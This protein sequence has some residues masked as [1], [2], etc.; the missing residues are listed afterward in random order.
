MAST[1]T[2]NDS[3][4]QN[5]NEDD[6]TALRFEDL[7]IDDELPLLDRVVR[8][9]RS[10]I[11]LQRLVHVKMLS[12]TAVT[13]GPA[14][15]ISHLI[16][17]LP[18]LVNDQE[19]IIRQ[20]LAMQLLPVSLTCMGLRDVDPLKDSYDISSYLSVP[21][22]KIQYD[23]YE[24]G[25]DIVMDLLLPK[26]LQKLISDQDQDVRKAA[27]DSI[28]K[29]SP[30]LRQIDVLSLVLP[31]ALNLTHVSVTTPKNS[32]K[33]N[34]KSNLQT[35]QQQQQQQQPDHEELKISAA[36]L[37]SYLSI[38]PSM[39]EHT[40]TNV[41]SPTLISL[42]KD[43]GSSFRVR[44]AIAQAIPRVVQKSSYENTKT[45]L[46]P[47]FLSLSHDDMYRV[48]KACAESLVDLS[49]GLS[50][51]PKKLEQRRKELIPLCKRLLNDSNK[52]VR[53]GMM[54]FLGPFIATFF[55]L[56]SIQQ[57][58]HHQQQQTSSFENGILPNYFPHHSPVSRVSSTTQNEKT[59]TLSNK[60]NLMSKALMSDQRML[61]EIM[62][63]RSQNPPSK[64]DIQH[65]KQDLIPAFCNMAI[66]KSGDPNIDAEMRVHCAYSLPAAALVLG[67]EEWASL[68]GAFFALVNGYSVKSD[69]T[70]DIETNSHV[71]EQN[72][73]MTVPTLAA[74]RCLASSLHSLAYI[75]G[76]TIVESELLPT[77]SY[78]FLKDTDEHV[79]LNAFKNLSS[80]L[81]VLRPQTRLNFLGVLEEFQSSS[82]I[83]RNQLN[84]RLRNTV[85]KQLVFFIHLYEKQQVHDVI[86]NTLFSL[87]KDPVAKVREDTYL[88]FPIILL[89]F[90]PSPRGKF[91]KEQIKWEEK[92]TKEIVNWLV[93]ELGRNKSD[94]SNRQ[95][96]CRI[97]ASIA[98]AISEGTDI[99]LEKPSNH[100]NSVMESDIDEESDTI[101]TNFTFSEASTVD[102]SSLP[103]QDFTLS[104]SSS[105]AGKFYLNARE[106]SHLHKILVHDLLSTALK[107]KDDN[108]T[109]VRLTLFKT[110][111]VMPGK[112]GTFRVTLYFFYFL[113]YVNMALY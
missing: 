78:S 17:L 68:R 97:C 80:F 44:K 49:K 25:Y 61:K 71:N 21:Q 106:K 13:Y 56:P 14:A 100:N 69:T 99:P 72:N 98:I 42:S 7:T 86:C 38:C 87:A 92:V 26:F 6:G 64:E 84:W 105:F 16:P 88:S 77:F 29:L 66:F 65:L 85:A 108:V 63:H 45:K 91:S 55:P 22:H 57:Q 31:M 37:L 94:F 18:A 82:K 89:K 30:Y 43:Q 41:V 62:Q 20:H 46:M 53:H 23:P 81:S 90:T 19:N 67:E 48:R 3:M 96:F 50:S 102:T 10:A 59:R 104:Y 9:C 11:A 54:Q 39:T 76:P 79:R 28:A 109:N 70:G 2:I 27:S 111:S 33:T 32:S 73:N 15:T 75:L 112:F 1:Q 47:L 58:Q 34:D 36:S 93:Y 113:M 52:F 95:A 103:V 4:P 107:L 5:N 24:E 12:E 101:T 110:L 74:K 83:N 60:T 51:H 8:Y 35:Q 40:I